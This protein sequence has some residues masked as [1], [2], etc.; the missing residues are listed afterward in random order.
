M[1][2]EIRNTIF[3]V[4]SKSE[5]WMQC[6]SMISVDWLHFFAPLRLCETIFFFVHAKEQIS[7][8]ADRQSKPQRGI[9]FASS[10]LCAKKEERA[11]KQEAKVPF[12]VE[13]LCASAPLRAKRR[14]S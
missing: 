8:S 5:R 10:L 4:L 14:K 9:F 12:A 1:K 7:L 13:F 11:E 6:Q 3:L 2:Y